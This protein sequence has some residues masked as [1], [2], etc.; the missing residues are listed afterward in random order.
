MV[1]PY[2]QVKCVA[3]SL[4]NQPAGEIGHKR[5]GCLPLISP[6]STVIFQAIWRHCL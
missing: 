6:R 4:G 1:V 2:S 3:K 5:S